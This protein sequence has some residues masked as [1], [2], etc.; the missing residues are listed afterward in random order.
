[1]MPVISAHRP[2][3]FIGLGEEKLCGGQ[4]RMWYE[5]FG[6]FK[7]KS[8]CFTHSSASFTDDAQNCSPRENWGV[9]SAFPHNHWLRQIIQNTYAWKW[10]V[11]LRTGKGTS[12]PCSSSCPKPRFQSRSL[13]LSLSVSCC[14]FLRCSP[15]CWIPLSAAC[16]VT[17]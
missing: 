17:E 5:A 2:I 7:T 14:S 1:M 4:G 16:L 6:P 10:S 11:E 13:S 12:P 9:W 15:R 8:I 3:G